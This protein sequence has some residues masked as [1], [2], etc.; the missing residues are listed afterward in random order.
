MKPEEFEVKLPKEHLLKNK[1]SNKYYKSKHGLNDR[2]TKAKPPYQNSHFPA[3]Y[4][5]QQ[6]ALQTRE[7]F[8]SCGSEFPEIIETPEGLGAILG[9]SLFISSKRFQK[10]RRA[11]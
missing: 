3:A 5:T 10:M 11:S 1:M 8:F 9:F 2:G 7:G 4:T 6:R